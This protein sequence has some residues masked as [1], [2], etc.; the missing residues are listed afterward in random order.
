MAIAIKLGMVGAVLHG[1]APASPPPPE[2]LARPILHAIA[3]FCWAGALAATTRGSGLAGAFG[4]SLSGA[5]PRSAGDVAGARARIESDARGA[6]ASAPGWTLALGTIGVVTFGALLR[7]TAG[8][9]HPAADAA[10]RETLANFPGWSIAVAF[11]LLPALGEE[12]FFR[13]TALRLAA[14]RV[15]AGAAAIGSALAF[16]AV[17]QGHPVSALA[18]G[19]A[20]AA[21]ALVAG[22]TREAI[23]AHASHNALGLAG[24][25]S[26]TGSAEW[27]LLVW[28]GAA[29]LVAASAWALL[30]MRPFSHRPPG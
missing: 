1:L 8:A 17:H 7:Q 24:L 19:L 25:A 9:G 4:T 21:L 11:V 14:G 29:G 18:F 26:P 22:R 30:R 10:L 12:A 6:R 5:G 28:I 16:A 15:G 23:L 20:L 2:S 3:W 13:G 27:P